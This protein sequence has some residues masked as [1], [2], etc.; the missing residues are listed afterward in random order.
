MSSARDLQPPANRR[1]AT[2]KDRNWLSMKKC[3][4][5]R[6]A[7][8][9]EPSR[10]SEQPRRGSGEYADGYRA[11]AAEIA[12]AIRYAPTG[13]PP[14]RLELELRDVEVEARTLARVVAVACKTVETC[15]RTRRPMPS[16]TVVGAFLH[17][18]TIAPG[19]APG[20]AS[21]GSSYRERQRTR[22]FRRSSRS[23]R[24]K[25][26]RGRMSPTRMTPEADE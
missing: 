4:R 7:V 25:F 14:T 10:N 13:Q 26:M 8:R 15:A 3:T 20:G 2:G 19:P 22:D 11:A 6:S 9:V 23:S 17:G 12:R 18:R 24:R 1:D 16:R 5:Q 21:R